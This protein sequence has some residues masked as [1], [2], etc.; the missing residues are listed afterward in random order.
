[1]IPNQP[2]LMSLV[3]MV[4]TLPDPPQAPKK[5]SRGRPDVF[6][7]KLFLKALVIRIVRHLYK[8]T[9]RI[10]SEGTQIEDDFFTLAQVRTQHMRKEHCGLMI[11]HIQVEK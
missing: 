9:S 5:R 2:L 7:N 4:D 1:M 3:K 10:R 11:S 6:S 8:D